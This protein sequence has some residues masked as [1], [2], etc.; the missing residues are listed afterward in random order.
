M[1]THYPITGIK[2]DDVNNI[3][4]R[5]ELHDWYVKATN[6]TDTR[7]ALQLSLFIHALDRFQAERFFGN[8]IKEQDAQL[9][10]FRV[11][12]R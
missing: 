5:L 1:A 8:D 4:K 2:V 7:A 3:P 6:G 10:Y 11:A 9:S 12:G